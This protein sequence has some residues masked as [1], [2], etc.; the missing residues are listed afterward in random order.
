MPRS[1]KHGSI[2][3]LSCT[4]SWHSAF[5]VKYKEIFTF[6]YHKI[7]RHC[8]GVWIARNPHSKCKFGST[9]KS[10]SHVASGWL[11]KG[12]SSSVSDVNRYVI[13]RNLLDST[14]NMLPE[15]LR[16]WI[17]QTRLHGTSLPEGCLHRV[18]R[19]LV[20]G[21]HGLTILLKRPEK[22]S[23]V[24]INRNWPTSC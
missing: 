9:W 21:V 11:N 20:R 5:V 17:I 14:V 8:T 23:D 22:R 24:R 2:R 18:W 6:Y 13:I 12:E 15:F 10:C 16:P 1:R 7:C 4:P 3:P 19:T